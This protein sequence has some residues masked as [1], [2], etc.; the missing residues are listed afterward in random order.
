MIKTPRQPFLKEP[1]LA[2]FCQALVRRG[3]LF[4]NLPLISF[5][6]NLIFLTVEIT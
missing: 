1:T 5:N 6:R 3:F 2:G 4:H